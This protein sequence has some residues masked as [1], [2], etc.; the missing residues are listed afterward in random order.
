MKCQEIGRTNVRR[1][2]EEKFGGNVPQPTRKRRLRK[3]CLDDILEDQLNLQKFYF[4]R[5]WVPFNL[6]MLFHIMQ[7]I[8]C[9]TVPGRLVLFCF[10]NFLCIKRNMLVLRKLTKPINYRFYILLFGSCLKKGMNIDFR[11]DLNDLEKMLI[12]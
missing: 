7:L 10:L 8:D 2:G 6:L 11:Q 9:G 4:F 5:P 1:F 3:K 12:I